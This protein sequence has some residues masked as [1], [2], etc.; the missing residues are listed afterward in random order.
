MINFLINIIR[1]SYQNVKTVFYNMWDFTRLFAIELN[2]SLSALFASWQPKIE[3]IKNAGSA[4]V[5]FISTFK[6]ALH[7]T[8]VVL[9]VL[10]ILSTAPLFHIILPSFLFEPLI[11]GPFLLGISIFMG[12]GT[13]K[14]LVERTRLDN[15]IETDQKII[16]TLNRRIQK[17]ELQYKKDHR[18]I[19]QLVN[20]NVKQQK[21]VYNLRSQK[22]PLPTVNPEITK[23]TPSVRLRRKTISA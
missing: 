13:Y 20:V 8:P 7:V 17:L 5:A 19:N 10:T 14:D 3:R 9:S 16:Q 21:K 23:K 12:I 15:L 6:S 18:R 1:R 22:Q 11:I 2:R 4:F